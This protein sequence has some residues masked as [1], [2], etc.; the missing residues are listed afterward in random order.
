[1]HQTPNICIANKFVGTPINKDQENAGGKKPEAITVKDDRS[2]NS[3]CKI[4]SLHQPVV[5]QNIV[6]LF[7]FHNI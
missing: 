2:K 6:K 5:L 3:R 7:A 4:S 1:M